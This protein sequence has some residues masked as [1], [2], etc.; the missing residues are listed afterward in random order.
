MNH[1]VYFWQ[2]NRTNPFSDCSLQFTTMFYAQC[3]K[4]TGLPREVVK[5]LQTLDL[6]FYPKNLRRYTVLY[7]HIDTMTKKFPMLPLEDSIY[8]ACYL[9]FSF[10]EISPMVALWQR[11]FLIITPPRLSIAFL[12]QRS[13]TFCQAEELEPDRAGERKQ[14]SKT[15]MSHQEKALDAVQL[16]NDWNRNIRT[17]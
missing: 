3:P 13:L 16:A 17:G 8:S 9:Y 7:I 2:S 4:K 15:V 6:S 11:Y 10:P 1:W 5:W 12:W 14:I